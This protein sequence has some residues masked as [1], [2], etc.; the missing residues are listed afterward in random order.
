MKR[1]EHEL[2]CV[3]SKS[4]MLATYGRDRDGRA[5]LH[6]RARKNDRI[7]TNTLHKGGEHD[8]WCSGCHRVTRVYLTPRGSKIISATD[9]VPAL[10]A[11]DQSITLPQPASQK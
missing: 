3:C 10:L 6:I 5:Y 2:R 4:V 7:I 8:L 9:R 1:T 11:E